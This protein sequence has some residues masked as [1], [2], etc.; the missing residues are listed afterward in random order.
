LPSLRSQTRAPVIILLAHQL[1]EVAPDQT[2]AD[3]YNWTF[4]ASAA[5]I[6]GFEQSTKL[7]SPFGPANPANTDET[8]D[9]YLLD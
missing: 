4:K 3:G 1:D 8:C 9:V 2:Y 5:Q 7:L 6:L